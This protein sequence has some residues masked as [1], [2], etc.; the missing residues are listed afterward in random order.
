MFINTF[1]T[2]MK[3]KKSI[4]DLFELV[5]AFSYYFFDIRKLFNLSVAIYTIGNVRKQDFS[6]GLYIVKCPQ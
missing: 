2:Y 5:K 6:L 4:N 1:Y 3:T